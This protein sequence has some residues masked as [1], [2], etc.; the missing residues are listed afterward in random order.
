LFI[1]LLSGGVVLLLELDGGVEAGGVGFV[2]GGVAVV[3]DDVVVVVSVDEVLGGVRLS[4]HAASASAQQTA[5]P[6]DCSVGMID[7]SIKLAG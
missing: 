4:L 7:S 2:I 6:A 3:F 1:A 5:M